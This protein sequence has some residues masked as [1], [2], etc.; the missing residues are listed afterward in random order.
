MLC[1]SMRFTTVMFRVYWPSLAVSHEAENSHIQQSAAQALPA[2]PQQHA[3]FSFH[4]HVPHTVQ[5]LH[6]V[7]RT[8]TSSQLAP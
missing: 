7:P 1:D 8:L 4:A 3:N 6:P 2:D 5:P